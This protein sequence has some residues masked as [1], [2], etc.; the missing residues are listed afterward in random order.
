MR[1][2]PITLIQRRRAALVGAVLAIAGAGWLPA[3][4]SASHSQIAI[5]Q[6]GGDLTNA[7]ATLQQFRALGATTI[8]VIVPWAT[9]AP[10]PSSTKKPNF[11][12]TDPNAYSASAWAP[13]DTIVRQAQVDG[14][15]VDLTVTGGA[16]RWAE[17][18]APPQPLDTPAVFV[19]WKPNA[20]AYGQFFRAVAER[21]DGSFT[22]KGQT[23]PLPAVHFW[24]IFNEPNFGLDLGPQAT[25]NSEVATGPLMFRSLLNAGWSALHAFP[26]HR[27][28]TILWGEFAAR[29]QG[30][31]A[32]LGVP[33]THPGNYAQ[34]KPLIFIRELFC[35]NS[36]YQPL[37]GSAAAA[38]G[39]PTNSAAA[40]RFRSQ[41]PALFTA[42]GVSDHPYPGN[43]NPLVDGTTDPNFAAFADLGNLEAVL[44]RV[45]RVY[46][47][48]KRYSIYNDEYG[49]ITDPPSGGQVAITGGHYVSPATAAYYINWAEY[50]SW[51]Q[52]RIASTM[53]YLLADPPPTAGAYAGFASGLEFYNG[54]PKADYAAYRLPVYMPVTSFSPASSV[55]VWGD[56]RP[57]PFMATDGDGPQRVAVQLNGKTLQTVNVTGS[58]GYFDIHM[59]FPRS[60][61]VRLAWTYPSSDPMLPIGDLGQTVYS[62]SFGIQVH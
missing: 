11:N 32:T 10:N 51:R 18:G 59:K 23:T 42:S 15:T 14:L 54:K 62:R 39:C 29:G 57:A 58:T 52:P 36:F 31:P 3:A 41:N 40:R 16:P 2:F 8:R 27:H 17:G 33:Q 37:T 9:I 45:N 5:I 48:G 13:Y 21:Y 25:N 55:E 47:S 1:S 46:G 38:I 35:V 60:G 19:A 28:D 26:S 44:D 50:L 20:A 53:Q 6:D 22:P 4:A 30:A 12:A 24:A 43:Q 56:A 49:Y 61:T 34:T 7:A